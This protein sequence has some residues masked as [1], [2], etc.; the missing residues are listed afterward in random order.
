[1]K[2]SL[3][4][5]A[6]ILLADKVTELCHGEESSNLANTTATNV[7]KH[8]ESDHNLPTKFLTEQ[9]LKNDIGIIQLFV[10]SGLVSSGK[11]AK[12]LITENGAKIN[13]EVIKS[14]NYK[15]KLNDFETPLKLSA[16]KKRHV[17]LKII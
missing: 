4:N 1:M 13:D 6:K 8:G 10:K 15:L 14:A 17:L 11:E 9:D 5:D 3:I 7:F 2:G 12:R 16:G